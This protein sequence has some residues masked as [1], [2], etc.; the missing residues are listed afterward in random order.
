[1]LELAGVLTWQHRIARIQVRERDLFGRMGEPLARHPHLQCLRVPRPAAAPRRRAGFQV[2]KSAGNTEPRDSITYRGAASRPGQ[3]AGARP[4]T[5]RDHHR[6][7]IAL[8]RVRRAGSRHLTQ[9]HGQY[10]RT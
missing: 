4:G 6:R 5:V 3:P 1:M 2:R 8:E 7:K 10:Q 9:A